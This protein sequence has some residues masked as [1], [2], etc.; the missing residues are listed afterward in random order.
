MVMMMMMMLMMMLAV[1]RSISYISYKLL[2][3]VGWIEASKTS[4]LLAVKTKMLTM[5]LT[6]VTNDSVGNGDDDGVNDG[7]D[8]AEKHL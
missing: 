2:I 8:S 6:V 5:A 4:V 7:L 3:V 1:L